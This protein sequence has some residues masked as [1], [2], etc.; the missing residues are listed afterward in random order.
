MYLLGDAQ[1][2]LAER[3]RTLSGVGN[4][5]SFYSDVVNC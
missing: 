3:F 1:V 4:F 2:K 5:R